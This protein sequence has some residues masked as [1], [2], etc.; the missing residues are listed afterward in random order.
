MQTYYSLTP[1][2]S[3]RNLKGDINEMVNLIHSRN[4]KAGWFTDIKTGKPLDRNIPEM[5]CLIHSE[6]SEAMEGY[7]K[8]IND[9]HLPERQMCEVELADALI[10]ILDLAGYLGYD[11]GG[12]VI[13]KMAY[14][15]NRADHK[16]ENRIKDNGKKI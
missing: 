13:E 1:V 12:A 14:N 4:V 8:N 7:R 9:D 6:I 10:R 2:L 5:L 3:D 16:I 15:L 11:L